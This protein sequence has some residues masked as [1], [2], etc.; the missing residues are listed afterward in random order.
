MVMNK[1]LLMGRLGKDP[2][3]KT[4]GSST[5]TK[6]S[7]ATSETWKDKDGHK[8]EKTQWHNVSFWG[9]SGEN[10][11]KY[12][13]KGDGI[14][15]EGSIEYGKYQDPA[16]K[17]DVNFTDV[18]GHRWEFTPGQKHGDSAASKQDD[19]GELPF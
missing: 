15:V 19:V 17:K 14:F 8:Q 9:P 3:T 18:K 12:F 13:H 4:V 7:L 6:F 1:V 11:A 2:E 5:V 16:T 10:L